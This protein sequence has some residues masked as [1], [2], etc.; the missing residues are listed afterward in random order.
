[1]ERL[2]SLSALEGRGNNKEMN[3][4]TEFKSGDKIAI[5]LKTR[6]LR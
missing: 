1:V 6:W 2:K 5:M 4:F 3:N